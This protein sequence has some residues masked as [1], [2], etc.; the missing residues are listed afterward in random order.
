MALRAITLGCSHPSVNRAAIREIALRNNLTRASV[1]ELKAAE[2]L[3]ELIPCVEMVKFGKHGSNAITAAVKISSAYAGRRHVCIPQQHPFFSFDDWFI[4]TTA[5]TR[6]IPEG[7]A[8]SILVFEYSDI[9]SFPSIQIR[10]Q[11]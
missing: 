5:F 9:D 3:T 6:L 7:A 4:G 8:N 2:R 1:T 11:P 10:L